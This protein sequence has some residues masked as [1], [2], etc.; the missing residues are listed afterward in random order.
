MVFAPDDYTRT[1]LVALGMIVLTVV[2]MELATLPAILLDPSI[3]TFDQETSRVA[4]MLFL[5]LNFVG[6]AIAGFIYLKVT[7]RRREW[8]DL[9]LPSK[10]DWIWIVGGSVLAIVVLFA[11]GL[12]MELADVDIPESPVL[13]LVEGDV[14]LLSVMFV[15]VWLLNAPAEELVFRNIIQKRS[16]AAFSGVGAVL[17]T[18]LLFGLI[19]LPAYLALGATWDALAIPAGVLVIGSVIIGF[20]YLKTKNLVVPILIHAIYNSIQIGLLLIATILG[21]EPVEAAIVWT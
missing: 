1:I 6:I 3:L 8:L 12:A 18:S 13:A 5:P 11:G 19:H 2:M 20:A 7:D 4:V 15:T 10:R 16:Y 14:M 9:H 21:I 17:F